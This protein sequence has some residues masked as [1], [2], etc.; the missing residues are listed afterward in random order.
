MEMILLKKQKRL[1]VPSIIAS[2]MVIMTLLISVGYSAFNTKLNVKDIKA[3]VRVEKDIRVT[4]I[5]VLSG[6]DGG[7][8]NWEDYNVSSISGSVR[9]PNANSAVRY[10]VEITNIG[11]VE[12][13]L[14]NIVNTN[15]PEELMA[16]TSYPYGTKIC[17][18]TTATKCT[19]GAKRTIEIVIKYNGGKYNSTTA[20]KDF[21]FNLGFT[22]K[23]VHKITYKNI[24]ATGLKTEILDT[25][26]L[27]ADIGTGYISFNITQGGVKLT[28]SQYTYQ[29]GQLTIKNVTGDLVIDGTRP[30][31]LYATIKNGAVMDNIKSANVSSDT[32]IDFK[33]SVSLIGGNGDGKYIFSSTSKNTYPVYY[34]RGGVSL[35]NNV[36]F[37]NLCWR[38]VRTTSTGGIKMIYNG[39]STN[40]ACSE[41]K[42]PIGGTPWDMNSQNQFHYKYF[43]GLEGGYTS[44]LQG[45]RSTMAQFLD[46]WYEDAIKQ[47]VSGTTH[48]Y[49]DYVEDTLW[50]QKVRDTDTSDENR[51]DTRIKNGMPIIDGYT[52]GRKDAS[53][54]YYSCMREDICDLIINNPI[55]LI[56]VD[57]AMLAGAGYSSQSLIPYISSY[58]YTMWLLTDIT[59]YDTDPKGDITNVKGFSNSPLNDWSLAILPSISLKNSVKYVNG[60]GSTS[61]PYEIYYD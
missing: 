14:L 39:E 60:T 28:D 32:G 11:N 3:V 13:G 21:T 59:M 29:N 47:S 49:S 9:L 20:S 31:S 30:I 37:A 57:E 46:F 4:N 54:G 55:G 42:D 8:S 18:N 19:L 45:D 58:D 48:K 12:M 52:V 41:K 27:I 2:V 38:I 22:F 7:V 26:I 35:K 6:T 61:A 36:L 43:Y 17:D 33:K 25:D 5:S 16:A 53:R 10:M 56:N 40:G 24:T 50:F 15:L 1:Q 51:Q 44:N 34:Y 23:Q